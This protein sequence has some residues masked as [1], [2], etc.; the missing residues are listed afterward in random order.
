MAVMADLAVCDSRPE[1]SLCEGRGTAAS[2]H[3]HHLGAR[4]PGLPLSGPGPGGP[5]APAE[6]GTMVLL[7]SSGSRGAVTVMVPQ[8]P[9]GASHFSSDSVLVR[10]L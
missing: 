8:I 7:A 3:W 4:R 6:D 5:A 1:L 10:H 2:N 9:R